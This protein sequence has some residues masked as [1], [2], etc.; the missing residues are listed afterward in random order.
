MLSPRETLHEQPVNF[1]HIKAGDIVIYKTSNH[2]KEESVRAF[3]K[4]KGI[5]M[6]PFERIMDEASPVVEETES[7]IDGNADLKKVEL[8]HALRGLDYAQRRI[9]MARGLGYITRA[10]HQAMRQ[11]L[12]HGFTL[13]DACDKISTDDRLHSPRHADQLQ[14]LCTKTNVWYVIDDTELVFCH[15][16]KVAKLPAG[17]QNE[18]SL[19]RI[20]E[21]LKS[22]DTP[23]DGEYPPEIR[24]TF[25]EIMGAQGND[26]NM[27]NA[28][29]SA[30]NHIDMERAARNTNDRSIRMV[31]DMTPEEKL[32]EQIDRDAH[33][34]FPGP[35]AADYYGSIGIKPVLHATHRA[36]GK[37]WADVVAISTTHMWI[38]Q[39]CADLHPADY[40]MQTR[41]MSIALRLMPW[42]DIRNDQHGLITSL[43]DVLTPPDFPGISVGKSYALMP[44]PNGAALSAREKIINELI[45]PDYGM[46]KRHIHHANNDHLDI[47]MVIPHSSEVDN[48]QIQKTIATI[49]ATGH[50]VV[51]YSLDQLFPEHY[52]QSESAPIDEIVVRDPAF[53]HLGDLYARHG[54]YVCVDP[55][56]VSN[57]PDKQQNLQYGQIVAELLTHSDV[58]TNHD[59]GQH[60]VMLTNSEATRSMSHKIMA[61]DKDAAG[62]G[63]VKNVH[64]GSSLHI[65]HNGPDND[66]RDIVESILTD[67]ADNSM[68]RLGGRA[69]ASD[70]LALPL[71]VQPAAANT[72]SDFP[73]RTDTLPVWQVRLFGSASKSNYY[74]QQRVKTTVDALIDE[75]TEQGIAV[76]LRH[77]NGRTGYMGFFADTFQT[78]NGMVIPSHGETTPELLLMEAGGALRSYKNG[79]S[80]DIRRRTHGVMDRIAPEQISLSILFDGGVG[81]LAEYLPT[82]LDQGPGQVVLVMPESAMKDKTREFCIEGDK[83][84]TLVNL[85]PPEDVRL[86]DHVRHQLR[87]MIDQVRS[88]TVDTGIHMTNHELRD[89]LGATPLPKLKNTVD[90]R[91]RRMQEKH[92]PGMVRIALGG[93]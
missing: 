38:V 93:G 59:R 45:G 9:N 1:E 43:D 87:D 76:D 30:I 33:L 44:R 34:P 72:S 27:V 54:I 63:Y 82:A 58:G 21:N 81:S 90:W 55:S 14:A 50:N 77:G 10:G 83:N 53:S 24:V 17:L 61:F 19:I 52:P 71:S 28:A 5:A 39:E 40:P 69:N 36:L 66:A 35:D 29:I 7:S 47:A 3:L 80:P 32:I 85:K 13:N 92:N 64:A 79:I 89:Q 49:E 73:A 68:I 84:P 23:P 86:Y 22:P 42:N 12:D 46:D 25:G 75:M 91:A 37:N 16:E 78:I 67:I 62:R 48:P 70:D 18:A 20:V 57:I 51:T 26:M 4:E 15:P 74:Y 60:V 11:M 65:I 41:T 88:Q 6:L 8:V 2:A 31:T 56:L